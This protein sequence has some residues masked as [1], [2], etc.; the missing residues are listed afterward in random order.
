MFIA[1]IYCLCLFALGTIVLE[2]FVEDFQEQ[3][4]DESQFLF[5]DQQGKCPMT[6]LYLCSLYS[7]D[8]EFLRINKASAA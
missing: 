4:F 2:P 8:V 1:F 5:E 6:I 7:V 3:A